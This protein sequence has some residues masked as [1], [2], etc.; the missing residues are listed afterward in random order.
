MTP[1]RLAFA[2]CESKEYLAN[3]YENKTKNVLRV[4]FNAIS[5]SSTS[6]LRCVTVQEIN[7]RVNSFPSA[8]SNKAYTLR[9]DNG[10]LPVYC[11]M[12]GELGECGDGGWTLVMKIDGEKVCLR[13][14]SS[15]NSMDFCSSSFLNEN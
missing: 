14:R 13:F 10:D 4:F 8:S 5:R 2:I 6:F 1:S 7:V 11:S 12:S 15:T 3:M 9:L